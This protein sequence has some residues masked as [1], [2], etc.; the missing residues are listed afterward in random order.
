MRKLL[1]WVVGRFEWVT[2]KVQG[3]LS[4]VFYNLLGCGSHMRI[5][6]G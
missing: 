1:L 5:T 2:N 4:S 3:G 6:C